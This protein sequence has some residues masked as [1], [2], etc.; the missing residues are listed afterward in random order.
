MSLSVDVTGQVD[1]ENQEQAEF[2]MFHYLTMA[3]RMFENAGLSVADRVPQD[4]SSPAIKAWLSEMD[5]LYP[6]D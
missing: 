6:D 5:G 4:Q 3:A 2:L 1:L